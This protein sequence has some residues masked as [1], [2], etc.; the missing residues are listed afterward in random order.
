MRT[1][2]LAP[3]LLKDDLSTG[4]KLAVFMQVKGV[5]S[6]S[7]GLA[8]A[9]YLLSAAQPLVLLDESTHFDGL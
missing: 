9:E 1:R 2:A 8:R 4:S 5:V 7:L 6:D 3:S